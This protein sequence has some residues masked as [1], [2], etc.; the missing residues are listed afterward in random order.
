MNRIGTITLMGAVATAL[1]MMGPVACGN[2]IGESE[3]PQLSVEQTEIQLT[4]MSS[5]DRT[6][7]LTGAVSLRNT[8]PGDL[9]IHSIEWV[10]K[11]DRVEAYHQGEVTE[12]LAD[13]DCS[14]SADCSEDGICL[15]QSSACR[16]R[17]FRDLS[18]T[19]GEQATFDQ[20]LVVLE[21]D[22]MIEC[23]EPADPDEVP[24]NYCGE[25]VIETNAH[26]TNEEMNI[27]DGTARI[28]I[29][30]DG[31]SG[32]PNL[33]TTFIEYNWA[34]PAETQTESFT[35]ENTASTP[36]T[37]DRM[38]VGTN[39]P[40]F[41]ETPSLNGLEI[42]GNSSE[43]IEVELTPAADADEEDL[44]F[45]T[46]FSFDT[47]ASS[48]MS[49]ITVRVT[50]GPGDSPL[51]EVEPLQLS[52]QDETTQTFEVRNHGGATLPV[53]GMSIS[54]PSVEDH[55]EVTLDGDDMLD[56]TPPNIPSADSEDE[57]TV[58]EFEI[59]LVDDDAETLVGDLEINHGDP[60]ADN[61]STISLLGDSEE[62]ALGSVVPTQI[63]MLAD[64]GDD[65]QQVRHL[66]LYNS[67][68]AA[69]D[70][71]NV[72]LDDDAGPT[73][74]DYFSVEAVESVDAGG[75]VTTGEMTD[76]TVPAGGVQE[77]VVIYEHDDEITDF[78][79]TL[80][81]TVES[82]DHAGQSNAMTFAVTTSQVG[83]TAM[84][85]EIVP[86]F[87]D[88]AQV[89]E[90]TDFDL[91]DGEGAADLDTADWVVLD[92]PDDSNAA[93]DGFGSEISL[94]IDA[95]GTYRIAATAD[96]GGSYEQQVI[97]EF[98]AVD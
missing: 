20:S 79:Q 60:L 33:S 26:T 73:D 37:I 1:A 78:S 59:E 84:D 8:G 91:E 56:G 90:L 34:A 95:A 14:S 77:F 21:S 7:A 46:E 48:N 69:M 39:S 94:D 15:T 86:G 55:Y 49:A 52:F 18:D 27:E 53:H 22:Q 63:G 74:A 58:E 17:G 23:P 10:E 97:F 19:I 89:G 40:W 82:D 66:A 6:R 88:Q 36:L 50:D 35:I 65:D 61:L 11:P 71:D 42:D 96:D 47:S 75:S 72:V 3:E 54:P 83:A 87:P 4:D 70:V 25:L 62:I 31:S 9:Q 30:G 93:F 67:G 16:D 5:D 92:R 44:N 51:I 43:T 29:V 38:N 24:D 28:F 57:P 85:L 68:D 81:V 41:T 32:E 80:W 45:Q 2:G 13:V 98:D 12:D 64:G 76:V